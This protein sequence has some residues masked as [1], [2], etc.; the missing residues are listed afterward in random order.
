MA[1]SEDSP[2]PAN[3]AELA[4]SKGGI[5]MHELTVIGIFG[6][7][8]GLKALVRTRRGK[9]SEVGVGDKVEGGTVVAIDP[10]QLA[11]RK[12]GRD[13]VLTLPRG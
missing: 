2:T 4:T 5:D 6:P 13:M 8:A 7:E 9:I 3:V 12:S 10:D 11:F 1:Q